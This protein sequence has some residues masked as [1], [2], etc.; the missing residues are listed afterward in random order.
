MS[1]DTRLEWTT[2]GQFK[3]FG[4]FSDA[5]EFL[6]GTGP[7]GDSLTETWYWGFSIPEANL[8]FFA[9]CWL[10]PNLNVASGGLAIWKG[11]KRQHLASEL[12]DWHTFISG[13]VIGDG[14][15]IR[16]PNGF[17][18]E[19]IEPLKHIHL[20]FSDPARD[21]QVDVHY[22][23]AQEPAMRANGQHFEQLMH[24]TGYVVLRGEHLTVDSFHLRDRSWGQ[25]R[26]EVANPGPPYTWVTGA[27][28]DG[29]WAFNVGSLD[30]P[31]RDPL[32]SQDYPGLASEAAYKDGWILRD[33]RT[34]HIKH[35]SRHTEYDPE[36]LRPTRFFI[37]IEDE[38]GE[39]M[40][41]TGDVIA[42]MPFSTWYNMIAHV[43]LV[44]WEVEG[45]P[46]A[47]GDST[48]VHWNDF[49]WRHGQ[50]EATPAHNA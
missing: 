46:T 31:E 39:H 28:E 36:S 4:T 42:S 12:F 23:A 33:G 35:A 27:A 8:N 25:L 11:I 10:H 22:K 44:R 15:D 34:I 2:S 48:E 45:R 17:R 6:H 49:V 47:Y 19:V 20:T 40:S 13:D 41:V 21:T 30:D 32:W 9:Y 43:A 38:E 29:S 14:S 18:A 24:A 50:L 3:G 5:D 7:E 37:E 1:N 26:P 16:L